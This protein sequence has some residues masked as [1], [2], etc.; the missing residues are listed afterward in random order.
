MKKVKT[1]EY[2]LAAKPVLKKL[3]AELL[4]RYE[5]A[6]VLADDSTGRVFGSSGKSKSISERSL[7]SERGFCVRIIDNG[8][9]AEHSFNEI[10]EDSIPEIIDFMERE[11]AELKKT[12]PNGISLRKTDIKE[13][14]EKTVFDRATEYGIHPEELGD[15]EIMR[16]LN[17]LVAKTLES[18]ER[19]TDAYVSLQYQQYT[20]LF[21]SKNKDMTQ[22]ILWTVGT[23]SVMVK[24]GES[25]RS[26]YKPCSCLGGAEVLDELE[27]LTEEAC[28]DALDL[29][30][31]EH[32]APGEYD[33]ICTPDVTGM[34]VH[35]AF[36]HGV[37]MDM[38][39]KDRALAKQYIGEYVA[40][41]L[42]TM[43]DGAGAIPQVAS[44]F[45]DDEG[46]IGSDTI[47]ID[48]G[49]LKQGIADSVSAAYLKTAPT[50][51]GRR[52]GYSNK[53]YTRMTNTIFEP[54]TSTVEEMI[55]S[56]KY[57][58]LLSMASSGMEDPK[59]WGIQCMVDMAREIKDGKLTGRV[60]SP[61]VLTGY[62]P[63]LLKSISMISSEFEAGG[64]GF[65]GKGHKEW[66]K[67]SDGG[68][69][70]KARI[71]LG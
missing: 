22:S 56:V 7:L 42:I 24:Q 32:I 12:V 31:S 54:G 69:Y 2:I 50:G 58:M 33:C 49:I 29:L 23:I 20:K 39:V 17:A 27:K 1:S 3:L 62:V 46:V 6:S 51:N 13:P 44:Y 26:A 52:E 41:P 67:V 38:F 4:D 5:Y 21:L 35:E 37:E 68:P 34:I 30:N 71:T 19:I 43:H 47:I 55:A 36:G 59:N 25:V 11:L 63:D 65:C 18:D 40:S 9:L 66:V 57:G 48:K 60:F 16:R 61:V 14:E 28:R 45:F 64:S 8:T 15:G 70:I 53:A 10:D